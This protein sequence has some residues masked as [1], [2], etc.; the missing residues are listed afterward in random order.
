MRRPHRFW[1][2]ILSLLFAASLAACS[3]GSQPKSTGGET[4]PANASAPTEAKPA[5][6]KRLVVGIWA[7]PDSFNPI[8]NTTGY[9]DLVV[10]LLFDSLVDQSAA[11]EWVAGLAERWEVS[12]D[13]RRFTFHLNPRAQWHDGRPVTADDVLFTFG[14]ISRKETPTVLRSRLATLE[15]TERDGSTPDGQIAGLTKSDDHTVTF[16]TK[17]PVDR[18]VFLEQVGNKIHIVPRH[19]LEGVAPAELAK[20]PF[21]LNPTV[22]SGA[23]KF[24]RYNVDQHVELARNPKYHKGEPKLD[25]LFIR[26]ANARTLP[27]LLESG[28]VDVT[29]GAGIGEVPIQDWKRITELPHIQAAPYVPMVYQ[30]ML[31]NNQLPQFQDKRVRQALALAI[32]R[33]QI[34]DQLLKGEGTVH[35]TPYNA[36]IKFYDKAIAE[37]LPFDLKRAEALLKE[38]GFDFSQELILLT[39]TGNQVREQSAELIQANLQ[40]IG[41]KVKIEKL[42]FATA[43][44]RM[45]KLDYQIGLVGL[46]LTFDP[47]LTAVFGSK[48]SNNYTGFANPAVDQLLQEARAT[49]EPGKR[50]QLYTELQ[51]RWVEEMP[52]VP[53]YTPNGLTVVNK[54]AVGIRPGANGPAPVGIA[55]NPEQWDVK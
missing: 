49:L 25:Q 26:I 30:A 15:G 43:F 29:A 1:A 14:L 34:V 39:P 22:G 6:P 47:D 13:S 40:Q 17:Q 31:I 9:G 10:H 53:L 19:V 52:F 20:H 11:K 7:S 54:R 12:A 50:K 8:T 4:A 16:V 38:A 36:N 23:F 3:S 21:S 2:A 37:G 48:G 33:Q 42:D 27:A 18:D 51:K 55:W 28:E 41:V 24:V 46:A 5:E 35:I 45:R 44:A 32:N